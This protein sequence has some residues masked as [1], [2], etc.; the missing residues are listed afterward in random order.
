M[1]TTISGRRASPLG[2]AAV[3]GQDPRCVRRAFRAGINCF[4]FYGP[5]HGDFIGALA[6]LLRARR[7]EMV[8]ATGSGSRTPRGLTEV[9]R[10]VLKRLSVPAVD[11]FFAEYVNPA[12]DPQA[13][14]GAGGV[15]DELQQW[16]RDGLVR[17][18]GA[19]A[20]D[21]GLARRL[22]GDPR[23]D[24]LMH[25]FNMAHRKA[26]DEVFPAAFQARTPVVAFTA[27]R[28]RTLLAPHDG[29][30]DPPGAADCYRYCLA[31]PAV[32]LVLT[33]PRTLD[34]LKQN[35]K[36]LTL[37]RMGRRDRSR[38]ERYGDLVYGAG[39]DAFETRW[40]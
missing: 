24:V 30:P 35:L 34:E 2:L 28:W 15:L 13:I 22:A 40:T 10:K 4:F 26:A 31:Q 1:I 11:V 8:V 36:V 14:F 18:V 3:P 7:E 6:P 32:Q 38:W 27:T 29:W 25:R 21:R 19:T 23:V 17:Y 5:G 37:P 39:R 9:R 33:A 20:H 16:K 12:D